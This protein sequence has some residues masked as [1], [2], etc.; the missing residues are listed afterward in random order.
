MDNFDYGKFIFETVSY[1]EIIA[2][3]K[4]VER[5][6]MSSSSELV[7]HWRGFISFSI[8]EFLWQPNQRVIYD[9]DLSKVI[10]DIKEYLMINY[11]S[12]KYLYNKYYR[13]G[14]EC[15]DELVK[16]IDHSIATC[17]KIDH[18]GFSSF[19]DHKKVMFARVDYLRNI[20]LFDIPEDLIKVAEAVYIK[21]EIIVLSIVKSN[22]K[23]NKE[24]LF[25][26]ENMSR[27]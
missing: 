2:G 5:E 8:S 24:K 18:R 25:Q 20:A 17:N 23:Y 16:C 7:I 12:D 19:R 15:Y 1:D 21:M 11:Y 14:I 26:L 9:I 22:M 6:Y 13:Y 3:Y 27:R 4:N 10:N